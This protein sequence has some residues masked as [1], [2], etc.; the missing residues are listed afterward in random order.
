MPTADD[1]TDGAVIQSEPL[2]PDVSQSE[3]AND[4]TKPNPEIAIKHDLQETEN[5]VQ[6][7]SQSGNNV[8]SVARQT[9]TLALDS[10][11]AAGNLDIA[12]PAHADEM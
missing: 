2:P 8:T 9:D 7:E 12:K 1:T 4:I 10:K 6:G 5:V 11:A 3:P